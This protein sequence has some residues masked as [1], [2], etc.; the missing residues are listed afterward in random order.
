MIVIARRP[1]RDIFHHIPAQTSIGM[2]ISPIELAKT[3]TI[4]VQLSRH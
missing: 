1:V 4:S 2:Y 3:E